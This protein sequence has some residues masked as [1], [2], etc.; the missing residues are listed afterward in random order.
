MVSA[1][2]IA[3]VGLIASPVLAST[4]QGGYGYGDIT[5]TIEGSSTESPASTGFPSPIVPITV[6]DSITVTKPATV[7]HTVTVSLPAC[8]PEETTTIEGT[9]ST[10]ITTR[11][12]IFVSIPASS[13]TSSETSKA[14]ETPGTPGI[15]ISI[16]TASVPASSLAT[17]AVGGST[18]SCDTT[19]TTDDIDGVTGSV[20]GYPNPTLTPPSFTHSWETSSA[21][22]SGTAKSTGGVGGTQT[23]SSPVP[24]G[25]I[26]TSMGSQNV[27]V[28]QFLVGAM[29]LV[30]LVF[31]MAL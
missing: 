4:P 6:T 14:T 29:G 20:P 1:K 28:A 23:S 16:A 18:S 22:K 31:S 27:V 2:V 13:E 19:A 15:S 25:T 11:N 17:S 5:D 9:T 24:Y 10:T 8:V 7:T 12:T 30:S 26:T 3:I 21:V